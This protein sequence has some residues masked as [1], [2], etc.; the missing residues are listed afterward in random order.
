MFY[1][2]HQNNPYRVIATSFG[3]TDIYWDLTEDYHSN[4]PLVGFIKNLDIQVMEQ[5]PENYSYETVKEIVN[6]YKE[7][8]TETNNGKDT[9][10]NHTVIFILSE[11][12]VDPL[13]IP[14]LELSDDPIPYIRSIKSETTSGGMVA[15]VDTV[16]DL[17]VNRVLIKVK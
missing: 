7:K 2:N 14:T 3:I 1:S 16:E 11:S 5:K 9:L 12:F 13:R 4:G 8:V 17:V 6:K 15:M 10:E